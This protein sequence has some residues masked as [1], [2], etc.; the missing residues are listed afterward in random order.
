MRTVFLSALTVLFLAAPAIADDDTIALPP[1]GTTIVNLSVTER[2]KLTQ[3]TLNASLR[4]ELDGGSANEIQDKINKAI[5]DAVT[6]SKKYSDVKTTTGGYYVYAYDQN[7]TIDPRTGQ[8]ISTTKKWRG[9]QTIDLES[10]N[11]T[12]LLELAGK[13][14]T[15]GFIM[16]GLTYSLSPEKAETVRDDLMQ[17]A[18]RNLGAKAKIAQ[19]ALGKGNYDIIDVNIDGSAP[20]VYPMY[21]TMARM[22]MA[23]A[24]SDVQAPTAEAGESEVTMTVNARVLLKP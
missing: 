11:S 22:E 12:Q 19:S 4:Y 3:D 5:A 15:L 17:K 14:Q 21:K 6:E 18:L 9:T 7:Q 24:A 20:P 16:N 2:T 23:Q 8:P 1:A 13:I 10:K